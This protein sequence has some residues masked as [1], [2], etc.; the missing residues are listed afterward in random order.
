MIGGAWWTLRIQS[1][2]QDGK[3]KSI[4]GYLDELLPE[5]DQLERSFDEMFARLDAQI[6]R[7]EARQQ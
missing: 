3:A 7:D 4:G 5:E 1:D 2:A 6:A